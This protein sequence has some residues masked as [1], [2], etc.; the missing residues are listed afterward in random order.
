MLRP[1]STSNNST[2]KGNERLMSDK[3]NPFSVASLRLNQ[4]FASLTPV[5]K[6][7]SIVRVGRPGAQDFIRV[8]PGE[9]H[10]ISPLGMIITKDDG[11]AYAVAPGLA[12]EV[13]GEMKSVTFTSASI[14]KR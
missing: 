1:A 9:D 11:E 6:E 5:K 3:K 4:N 14:A 10:R 7:I 12:P 2:L 13:A 8:Y